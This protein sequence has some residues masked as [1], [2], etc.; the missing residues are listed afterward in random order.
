[1]TLFFAPALKAWAL[2]EGLTAQEYD[3]LAAAAHDDAE[4]V[5]AINAAL[6][7]LPEALL[8]R[9]LPC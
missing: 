9:S 4:L 7:A 6:F 3:D 8:L 5:D 2:F 1:M